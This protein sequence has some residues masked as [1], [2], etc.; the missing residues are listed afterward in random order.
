MKGLGFEYKDSDPYDD[1]QLRTTA[2]S[3]CAE[4]GDPWYAF[5]DSTHRIVLLI[6]RVRVLSELKSRFDHFLKTGDDS[7]I[8]SDLT[9]VTFRTVRPSPRCSLARD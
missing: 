5:C 6:R 9:S 2:I 7:K 3:Q 8:P 1:V 4:A